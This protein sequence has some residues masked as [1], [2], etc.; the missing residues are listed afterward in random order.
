MFFF[1]ENMEE[2]KI[3]Q[4]KSFQIISFNVQKYQEDQ[5]S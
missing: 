4:Q 2:K 3:Q 5:F 1:S